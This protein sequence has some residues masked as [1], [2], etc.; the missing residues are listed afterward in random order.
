MNHVDLIGKRVEIP[1]HY[2]MW[3]RGAR[4]GTVTMYRRGRVN[5]SDYVYVKLDHPQAKRSLKIW[6]HDWEYM[7]IVQP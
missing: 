1:V 7:K 3:M 5:Q 2:D 6:H 4:Y